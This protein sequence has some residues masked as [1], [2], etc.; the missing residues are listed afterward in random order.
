MC[1]DQPC[2][3]VV[4]VYDT[5]RA[6]LM[7]IHQPCPSTSVPSMSKPTPISDSSKKRSTSAGP[8]TRLGTIKRLK[9]ETGEQATPGT[10]I[11]KV[12]ATLSQPKKKRSKSEPIHV[13]RGAQSRAQQTHADLDIKNPPPESATVKYAVKDWAHGNLSPQGLQELMVH[14]ESDIQR[15]VKKSLEDNKPYA[16][17]DMKKLANLGARGDRPSNMRRDLE[18]NLV[19]AR[20]DEPLSLE[21]PMRNDHEESGFEM[22]VQPFVPPYQTFSTLYNEYP[23]SGRKMYCQARKNWRSFGRKWKATLKCLGIP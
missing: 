10:A 8:R 7:C 16:Y 15:A 21:L 11:P 1:I 19:P 6:T 4:T 3:H 18:N 5:L 17:K 23:T 14:V 20:F 9:Q 13:G 2:N 12:I 22:R